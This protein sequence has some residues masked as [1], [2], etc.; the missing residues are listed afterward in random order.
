MPFLKVLGAMLHSFSTVYLV[1]ES[2]LHGLL[3]LLVVLGPSVWLLPTGMFL[4][5]KC[6]R[7]HL[8]DL[9]SSQWGNPLRGVYTLLRSSNHSFLAGWLQV[10]VT[11]SVPDYALANSCRQARA[12]FTNVSI[13]PF[14]H[15][16]L[17]LLHSASCYWLLLL[18]TC[19]W[20]S[21]QVFHWSDS[22]L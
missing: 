3:Q 22:K 14:R 12:L 2:S 7:S 10:T 11:R 1:L 6:Q 8:M 17:V 9:N 4:V 18:I 5:L 20:K 16:N 15:Q 19:R 13:L 21:Q